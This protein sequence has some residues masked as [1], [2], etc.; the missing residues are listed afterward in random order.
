VWNGTTLANLDATAWHTYR[1]ARAGGT[2]VHSVFV[3]GVLVAEN[4][5]TGFTYNS[6]TLYRCLLGSPGSGWTGKAQ[7]AWLRFDKGAYAPLDPNDKSR[8]KAST[9][10][11]TQYEMA[12]DDA[13]ISTS[14]NASDWTI[15]GQSGATISKS[16]GLLSVVPNGKQTYWLSSDLAWKDVVTVDTAFTVDFSA[17]INSCTIDGGDRTL[18][19]WV[20]TPRATGNVIIGMN[21]VYWQVSK[22]MND[23]ILLD[24]SDN[25][26][27]KH[28]F[29][30][31]Y[32]G[33]TRH[34]FTVWRDG[35]KIGE[36]LV[37]LTTYNGASFSFARFGIPGS[38]SGGAF[39]ID[40][41]RWDTT[42]AYEWKDPPAAFTIVIR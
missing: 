16:G 42:G 40:Y 39:D 14:A 8:L 13:R 3:D 37:D 17:K 31:S 26:D 21:H 30:V 25:S 19:F 11:A 18:Q 5:G 24:S 10:F 2:S 32:D 20:G 12:D 33:A 38:T 29:R 9:D 28:V 41:I 1:I 35:V 4:L 7:V 23:N 27:G 34:G 15:S 22:A 6:S 36:N